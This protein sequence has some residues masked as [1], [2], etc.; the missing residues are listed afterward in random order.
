MVT[1]RMAQPSRALASGPQHIS[2]LLPRR[3]GLVCFLLLAAL[4]FNAIPSENLTTQNH[5]TTQRR[6]GNT[7]QW[8]GRGGIQGPGFNPHYREKDYT[9]RPISEK[10]I[11]ERENQMITTL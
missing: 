6:A 4:N 2:P 3:I 10:V 9:E 11:T 8:K 5:L 1:A 7:P